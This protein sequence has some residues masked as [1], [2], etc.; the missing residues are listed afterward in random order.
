VNNTGKP[1][2]LARV[3]VAPSWGGQGGGDTFEINVTVNGVEDVDRARELG[4]A[5][6]EELWDTVQVMKRGGK[7]HG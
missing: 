3:D 6:A 1:E 5:A 4:R 7:R 2:P